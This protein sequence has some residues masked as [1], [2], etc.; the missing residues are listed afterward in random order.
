[1]NFFRSI[2]LRVRFF[3]VLAIIVA[4]YITGFFNPGLE[5]AGHVLLLVF[6]VTTIADLLLLFSRSNAIEAKRTTPK[7]F[8][9]GDANKVHIEKPPIIL[10]RFLYL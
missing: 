2:F 4:T 7:R 5:V 6:L 10:F 9:N 3:V 1:M 8:S